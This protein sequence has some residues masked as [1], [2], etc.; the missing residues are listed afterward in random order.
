MELY[1]LLT[2]NPKAAN[3]CW[4]EDVYWRHVHAAA[5]KLPEEAIEAAKAR[6]RDKDFWAVT[7]ELYLTY[8]DLQAISQ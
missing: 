6:G 1:G 7:E 3:S 5:E 2:G 4:F 8:K